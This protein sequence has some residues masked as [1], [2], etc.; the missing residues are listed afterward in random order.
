MT[1][2]L[3]I[4]IGTT[5]T[6]AAV[7]RDGQVRIVE[8]GNRAATA[9]SV[10]FL[11]D[12]DSLLAGDAA[13]RRSVSEPNRVAREFKRRIGDPTAVLVGGAPYSSASLTAKL[14][15][16]VLARV[17]EHEGESPSSVVVTHP[18]NW[19][20]YKLDLFQQALRLADMTD[21]ALCSEPVAAAVHH[22]TLE[23]VKADMHVAVFDLGGGTFDA[24]VLRKDTDGFAILGQPEGIE[25]LG[26]I[27]FDEAVF[28]FVQRSLGGIF[29]ELDHQDPPT[30]AAV[31]R[32][33]ADCVEAKEALSGDT[34]AVIPVVLPNVTTEV[35]IT[36]A[37]FEDLVRP[38]LH[39]ALDSLRR[40]I[41]SAGLEPKDID[42]ALLVGGSSRIPLVGEL[43]GHEFAIPVAVHAHPKHV[44]ALGASWLAAMPAP[45]DVSASG[46]LSASPPR[47]PTPT[48]T[49][50]TPTATQPTV[51]AGQVPPTVRE[52]STR[53]K[54]PWLIGA[55]G[56]VVAALLA[57]F[58]FAGSSNQSDAATPSPSLVATAAPVPTTA[59]PTVTAQ[60]TAVPQVADLATAT[61][62]PTATVLPSP[63]PIP[64]PP[65]FVCASG[66]CAHI[67]DV[68]IVDGEFLITWS[69]HGFEPSVTN[70]HAHFFYDIYRAEQ[71]GTNFAQNG[72]Q[73]QG[74]WQVTDQQPFSTA[75][76][77]VSIGNAPAGT[78]R[79]CVVPAD[80]GHGVANPENVEC[81][82]I[83]PELTP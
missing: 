47:Q 12:D 31:A 46:N 61:P 11:K 37:E 72:A 54:V 1:Y 36:R 56:V 71:V 3:G 75:N 26:G 33:R 80:S 69:A 32:L 49:Q 45:T 76:S 51:A 23:P 18:A 20:P 38:S 63:T 55:A 42:L 21:A 65:P 58:A 7:H 43:V 66:L 15:A 8:L 73:S 9:P 17:T 6:A 82:V 24:A 77:A 74:S 70:F 2:E 5:Y 52:T 25:R 64:A 16:W 53:S 40:A 60:A 22:A 35:R 13:N 78:S 79:I 27:D 4:D 30:I 83:P 39:D 34:E 29:E 41:R 59:A 50:P 14:L 67:E 81:V 68:E 44:V 57:F 62:L 48:A 10:L 19:G 28:S